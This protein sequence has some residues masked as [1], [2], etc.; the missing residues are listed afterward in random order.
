MTIRIL[1]GLFMVFSGVSGLLAGPDAAGIPEPM[2]EV[3]QS[4]WSSGIFQMIKVTETIAGLMLVLNF[5]P[6]LA[7]IFL[8]PISLGV[9]IFNARLAPAFLPMGIILVLLTAYLGY[10]YWDKYKALLKIK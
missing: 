4:F 6:A 9:V 8:A 3:T 1:F 7:A 5:L 10:V 2:M